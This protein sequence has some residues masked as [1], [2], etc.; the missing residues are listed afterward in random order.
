MKSKRI[1]R[2]VKVPKESC[3][4][5]WCGMTMMMMMMTTMIQVIREEQTENTDFSVNV[6]NFYAGREISNFGRE[7]CYI[8][9]YYFVVF[10][11]LYKFLDT[12]TV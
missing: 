9:F 12:T 1:Y 6:S 5:T 2:R 7:I 3:N 8:D 11:S 4:S 10:L